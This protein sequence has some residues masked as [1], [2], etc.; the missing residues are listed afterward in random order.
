M[1]LV[2]YQPLSQTGASQMRRPYTGAIL[3]FPPYKK[4]KTFIWPYLRF[5]YIKIGATSI[6]TDSSSFGIYFFYGMLQSFLSTILK[7]N[8]IICHPNTTLH[9]CKS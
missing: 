8:K 3:S 2:C 1:F 9:P 6:D 7:T 5:F 4:I